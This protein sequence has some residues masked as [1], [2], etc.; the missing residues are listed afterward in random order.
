M[1]MPTGWESL[2]KLLRQSNPHGGARVKSQTVA[3]VSPT[4]SY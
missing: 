2:Q 3:K 4:L 1:L